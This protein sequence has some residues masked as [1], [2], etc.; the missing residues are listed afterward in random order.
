MKKPTKF[1]IQVTVEYSDD[2]GQAMQRRFSVNEKDSY[3][4]FM[5]E[6]HKVF[7]TTR[8]TFGPEEFDK[9]ERTVEIVEV[10]DIVESTEGPIDSGQTSPPVATGEKTP[11]KHTEE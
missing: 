1:V 10:A 7:E 9:I 5:A 4:E 2:A 6:C 8:F 3:D 11:V